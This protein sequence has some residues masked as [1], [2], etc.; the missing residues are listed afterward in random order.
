M[1]SLQFA[2]YGCHEVAGDDTGLLGGHQTSPGVES[3]YSAKTL[4][5]LAAKAATIH[6]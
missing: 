3:S 1:L 4:A 6:N 2:C 5:E